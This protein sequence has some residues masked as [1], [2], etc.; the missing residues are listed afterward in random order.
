MTITG[1]TEPVRAAME[2]VNATVLCENNLLMRTC[3]HG[4][5]HPVGHLDGRTVRADDP[6]TGLA[7]D[8]HFGVSAT[9]PLVFR[10]ECD[11]C[12]ASWVTP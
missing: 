8:P 2:A 12:C 7:G 11:G 1:V 10:A 5:R 4:I 9:A 6:R 3:E